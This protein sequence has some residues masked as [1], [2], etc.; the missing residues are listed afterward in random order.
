MTNQTTA[1]VFSPGASLARRAKVTLGLTA[2]GAFAGAVAGGL[3]AVAV[4]AIIDGTVRSVFSGSLFVIGAEIGAPLGAFLLPI[5]G[6]TLLRRVS[7][8]RVM[9]GTVLGTLVG[10]FAGWFITMDTNAIFRSIAGGVI[11]FF[12]AAVLMRLRARVAS[13]AATYSSDGAFKN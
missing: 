5:A 7:F 4:A 9:V 3:S 1:L 13:P 2:L 11:G 10:G 8:G 6:W 12:T